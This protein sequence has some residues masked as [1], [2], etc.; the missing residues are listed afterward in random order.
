M[1]LKNAVNRM[2]KVKASGSSNTQ[3][4]GFFE[5]LEQACDKYLSAGGDKK[6]HSSKAKA[7]NSFKK[8][9]HYVPA[10]NPNDFFFL[11]T[12]LAAVL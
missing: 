2:I 10:A 9:Q 8:Y 5:S 6:K 4:Q 11:S 1:E 7:P 12:L 3:K